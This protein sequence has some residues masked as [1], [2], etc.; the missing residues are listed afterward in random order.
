M[1]R[2]SYFQNS[3]FFT[4]FCVFPHQ[5]LFFFFFFFLANKISLAITQ[6]N[7]KSHKLFWFENIIGQ[8]RKIKKNKKH[9]LNCFFF[10]KISNRPHFFF[11]RLLHGLLVLLFP[12]LSSFV[13]LLPFFCFCSFLFFYFSIFYLLPFDFWVLFTFWFMCNLCLLS[14]TFCFLVYVLPLV[15]Y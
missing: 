3:L 8:R 9:E 15:L 10:W 11:S 4:C 5:N 2:F 7:K 14:F 13:S 6:E 12:F 1:S